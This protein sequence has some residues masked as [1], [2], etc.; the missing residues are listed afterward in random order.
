[1]TEAREI[2][3]ATWKIIPVVVLNTLPFLT[4]TPASLK[5]CRIPGPLRPDAM[6]LVR[7]IIP[8]KN[9]ADINIIISPAI[10]DN[11]EPGEQQHKEHEYKCIQ[12]VVLYLPRL[13]HSYLFEK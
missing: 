11:I 8:G 9:I 3:G 10:S 2:T 1:M 6:L 4:R 7:R 5:G 12:D 13:H